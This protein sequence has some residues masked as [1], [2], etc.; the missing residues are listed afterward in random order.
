ML[1]RAAMLLLAAPLAFATPA[2]ADPIVEG[3]WGVGVV[4]CDPSLRLTLVETGSTQVPV[5]AGTC[6]YVTV[7]T[8]REGGY[9]QQACVDYRTT[10]GWN[11]SVCAYDQEQVDLYLT[12]IVCFVQ[13]SEWC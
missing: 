11:E 13:P 2:K 9:P 12:A 7:P 8:V 6:R 3:C 5:C 4:V 1:K 10:A